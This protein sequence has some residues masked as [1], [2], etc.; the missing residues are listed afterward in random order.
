[1]GSSSKLGFAVVGW[2]LLAGI[3]V[4]EALPSTI[5]F[6]GFSGRESVYHLSRV[7]CFWAAMANSSMRCDSWSFARKMIACDRFEAIAQA[8]SPHTLFCAFFDVPAATCETLS[9]TA[10]A[11]KTSF[12][13]GNTAG[14]R[15]LFSRHTTMALVVLYLIYSQVSTVVSFRAD[16]GLAITYY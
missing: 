1:M 2:F 9:A 13:Y 8:L 6:Q 5:V 14:Q 3:V 10:T 16:H 4:C 11:L 12:D 7:P 15:R